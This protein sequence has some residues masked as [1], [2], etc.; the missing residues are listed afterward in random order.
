MNKPKVLFTFHYGKDNLKKVED[1]GYEVSFIREEELTKE[2]EKT[3]YEVI[4]CYDPFREM[5]LASMPS[6]K[7]VQ[8]VSKGINHV[9][10]DLVRSGRVTITNNAA[11]TSVP[12]AELVVSYLLQIYKQAPLFHK[13]QQEKNWAVCKDILEVYGKTVGFLGTGKIAAEAARR[14]KAFDAVILGFNHTGRSNCP[15]F[16]EV[17]PL[18]SLEEFLSRCDTVV[19]TLPH[20]EETYHLLDSRALS[21]MK[22]GS[23]IINVSR[24]SIIDEE[25][26][27][28]KLNENHFRGVALDVFEK[29]PLPPDSPLW[30]MENVI[31]TPHNALYSDLY[32]RRVFDMIYENLRRYLSGEPLENIADFTKGY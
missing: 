28:E 16:D 4:V 5:N 7:W 23:S 10:E 9:P 8:L 17:F 18:E 3:P 27:I 29:E 21:M 22:K 25:A 31:I 1:L 13:R 19:S 12:I 15:H 14:L 20:T 24:G 11:A 32:V 2:A 26:L 30:S 6:L